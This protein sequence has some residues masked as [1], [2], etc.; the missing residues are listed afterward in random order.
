MGINLVDWLK[1]IGI[2][3]F[4]SGIIILM[5]LSTENNILGWLLYLFLNTKRMEF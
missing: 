4:I 3:I 1:L 2:L 5:N